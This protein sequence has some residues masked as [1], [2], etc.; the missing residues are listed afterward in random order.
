MARPIALKNLP[1]TLGAASKAVP[2]SQVQILVP[3]FE[4]YIPS[5]GAVCYLGDDL[6]TT[7]YIP[8]GIGTLTA[9]NASE[10][11]DFS[12]GDYFDLSKLYLVSAT[13]NATAI[14]SYP[15]PASEV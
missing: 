13:A 4:L 12:C 15:A 9:F 2:L 8:R 14:V 3:W 6:V 7:S 11:G 5:G 10:K 1:V